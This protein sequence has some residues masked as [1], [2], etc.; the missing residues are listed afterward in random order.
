MLLWQS[1][2]Q[3]LH[4]THQ[5]EVVMEPLFSTLD[6]NNGVPGPANHAHAGSADR[7]ATQALLQFASRTLPVKQIIH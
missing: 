7:N 5:D 1:M 2:Q 3:G 6:L 4:H